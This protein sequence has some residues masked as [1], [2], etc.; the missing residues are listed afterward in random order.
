MSLFVAAF[1][2]ADAPGSAIALGNGE[3]L[4]VTQIAASRNL[5]HAYYDQA[6]S[7]IP[8]IFPDFELITHQRA[9]AVTVRRGML[10]SLV[11]YKKTGGHHEVAIG[12]VVTGAGKAWSFRATVA[13]RAHADTLR[14][15]LEALSKL[16]EQWRGGSSEPP[17]GRRGAPG[18]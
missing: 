9:A 11:S 1:A 4:L 5:P 18:S 17:A 15:L 16:P 8:Q 7:S 14:L 13:E 10:Y 2:A 12:G 6:M 3:V